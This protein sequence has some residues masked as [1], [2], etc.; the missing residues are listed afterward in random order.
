MPE[1]STSLGCLNA[2]KLY[3]G[4]KFDVTIPVGVNQNKGD[5]SVDFRGGAVGT[6]VVAQGEADLK[7]VKYEVTLRASSEDLFESVILDY[8]TPEEVAQNTKSSRLQLAMPTPPAPKCMRFDVTMYLPPAAKT[9]HIQTHATTQIK[10][11]PDSNFN[12]NT[13]FVTL[14]KLDGRN[15]VLPTEGVHAGTT[16]ARAAARTFV[17]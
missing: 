12:L 2:P 16:T 6:I 13:L 17:Q 14:Y 7:D 5:H 8:P 11:D 15:M 10:F 3:N 4:G 1:F 9:L